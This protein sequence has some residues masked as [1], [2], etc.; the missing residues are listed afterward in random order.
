MY[1]K[2]KKKDQIGNYNSLKSMDQRHFTRY[3]TPFLRFFVYFI[4]LFT[5][6]TVII[7][8]LYPLAISFEVGV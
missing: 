8:K 2:K 4:D 3:R 7:E 6:I 5:L 1:Y